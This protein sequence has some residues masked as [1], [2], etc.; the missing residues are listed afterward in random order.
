M[1]VFE[2]QQTL[3]V[4]LKEQIRQTL[5]VISVPSYTKRIDDARS[6][7][8]YTPAE[9]LVSKLTFS[10]IVELLSIEDPLVR[11]SMRRNVF[12]EHGACANCTV[13][14]SLISTFASD[15][16]RIK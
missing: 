11:F 1:Q 6:S 15:C 4:E 2:I 3:P 16:R 13:R 5:S 7:E 8:F 12:G 14:L 9:T 10:H